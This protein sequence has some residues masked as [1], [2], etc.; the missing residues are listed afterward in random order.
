MKKA[1]LFIGIAVVAAT[2]ATVVLAQSATAQ[3]NRTRRAFDIRDDRSVRQTQSIWRKLKLQAD[4]QAL[5]LPAAQTER[6][7][8]FESVIP[9][10]V[11]AQDVTALSVIQTPDGVVVT[12]FDPDGNQTI[13]TASGKLTGDVLPVRSIHWR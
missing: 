11:Q 12:V 5:A 9:R 1:V 6:W 13:Y 4:S 8:R 7:Q 3:R 10:L 2:A